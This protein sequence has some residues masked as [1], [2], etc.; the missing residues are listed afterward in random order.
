MLGELNAKCPSVRG[1]RKYILEKKDADWTDRC[2]ALSA[3]SAVGLAG[4]VYH[5]AFLDYLVRLRDPFL[6][7]IKDLRSSVVKEACSAIGVLAKQFHLRSNRL[8]SA[9]VSL[10]LA[11]IGACL[12]QVPV[13]IKVISE[14][15]DTCIRTVLTAL[16]PY[17]SER[18]QS[19]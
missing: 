17:G 2:D 15:A 5:E 18:I 13:T 19:H 14:S 11:I 3:L 6:V 4:G 8:P 16:A 12:K 10:S 9:W 1:L 7:Q